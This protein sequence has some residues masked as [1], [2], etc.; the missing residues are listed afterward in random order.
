MAHLIRL[1][2]EHCDYPAEQ[3]LNQLIYCKRG[4]KRAYEHRDV[5]YIMTIVG[6]C[7]N[8]RSQW[9]GYSDR[10][11]DSVYYGDRE[12]YANYLVY[13]SSDLRTITVCLWMLKR[14]ERFDLQ[15]LIL[16]NVFTMCGNC[17]V[18]R[19][20]LTT[21]GFLLWHFGGLH[22]NDWRFE[23]QKLREFIE[24]DDDQFMF[25][26]C[27]YIDKLISVTCQ[28]AYFYSDDNVVSWDIIHPIYLCYFSERV[29]QP[30]QGHLYNP[31]ELAKFQ[32][33]MCN[34]VACTFDCTRP[35]GKHSLVRNTAS[36]KRLRQ[37]S[38]DDMFY[39]NFPRITGPLTTPIDRPLPP[40]RSL[41]TY[42]E[43]VNANDARG[44][45]ERMARRRFG[46]LE[47]VRTSYPDWK[48]YSGP[49]L[50]CI[51]PSS[52]DSADDFTLEWVKTCGSFITKLNASYKCFTM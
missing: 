13:T 2:V 43:L 23:I 35:C 14:F 28:H 6:G 17:R 51:Y 41:Y 3:M 7:Y 44:T 25:N 33:V 42:E 4:L 39:L 8:L 32:E 12:L 40:S 45:G 16:Q 37:L 36:L 15:N 48:V 26:D 20:Y 29:G 18:F 49:Y 30:S 38:L 11:F 52:E 27:K 19:S 24:D 47:T 5:G 31:F 21:I 22:N 10:D 1:R 46:L 34:L 9:V 50:E